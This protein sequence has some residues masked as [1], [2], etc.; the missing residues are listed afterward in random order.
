VEKR[1]LHRMS[2]RRRIIPTPPTDKMLDQESNF[3]LDSIRSERLR[4]KQ[5]PIVPEYNALYDK[6]SRRYFRRKLVQNVL[7]RTLETPQRLYPTITFF[8]PTK[9]DIV[10]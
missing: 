4:N 1:G 3:V 6:N 7:R 10:V 2:A 8:A 5:A 9:N